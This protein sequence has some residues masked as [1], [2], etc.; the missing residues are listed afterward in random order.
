MIERVATD[1]FGA[2][3][4]AHGFAAARWDALGTTARLVVADAGAL[5]DARSAVE[6]ALD[7]IDLAAS[8]FRPDSELEL[9]NH[10][11]GAWRDASPLF[12]RALRVAL[13]AASWTD[14]LVDPTVG[15]S[16]IGLGYDRTFRL[17]PTDGPA[18]SIGL[19]AAP[20]WQQVELDDEA[21]RVRIPSGVLLDLGATAKGLASDIAARDAAAITGAGVLVSLGGDIAVAGP[22]PSGGWPVLVED[23]HEAVDPDAPHETIALHGGGLATSSTHARR[24]RRGGSELHHIIDPRSGGSTRGPWRTASALAETCVLANAASTAAMVIGAGAPRWLAD[25]GI[26]A[27]LVSHDGAVTRVTGW[28]SDDGEVT[29]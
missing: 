19:R 23:V 27:R 3:A 20:G 18:I 15:A 28:P 10:A 12:V 4:T 9:L 6:A 26:A 14:G 1:P 2:A 16:L 11:G 5:A 25:R 8:R 21:A 13:D 24:W 7:A 22:T 17:V 29:A